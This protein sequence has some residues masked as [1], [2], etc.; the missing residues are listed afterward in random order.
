MEVMER[1]ET[2]EPLARAQILVVDDEPGMRNFLVKTLRPLCRGVDE[3]ANAA[4]AEQCLARQHYDVMLLD[5]IMPGTKGLDWLAE[6]QRT[7][8][9]TETIMITA[10]ADFHIAL[11]ALRAGASDLVLK[12]FRWSSRKHPGAKFTP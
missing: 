9:F 1:P 5:N 11:E 6:R 3:A 10:Y 8:G 2:S 12:P 4:E 7:G